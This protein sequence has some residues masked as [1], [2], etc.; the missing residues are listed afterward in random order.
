MVTFSCEACNESMLKK[1][2]DQ[3]TQRCRGAYFTCIDCSTTFNGNEYRQ[4]TS[5][6]T[7][8]QK[9]QKA[10]Y[11]P[12]KQQQQKPQPGQPKKSEPAPEPAPK[13]E[14]A[15]STASA[16]SKFDLKSHKGK[17]LYKV[18]KTMSKD[19][20]KDILKRIT[21]TEDGTLQFK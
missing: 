15:K 1:K 16:S 19:Q 18:I 10:L 2:A 5:C 3:H 6:I 21:I 20:K 7:E 13:K 12:K 9:Y 8:D 17:G 14:T 11:R 4:H